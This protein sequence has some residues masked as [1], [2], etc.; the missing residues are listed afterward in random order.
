MA[1][2]FPASRASV[3]RR[4]EVAGRDGLA[5]V[6]NAVNGD[7]APAFYEE[8]QHARVQLADMAQLKQAIA[9]ALVSGSR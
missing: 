2:A 6:A 8:P 5:F 3:P 9:S 4:V 7:D 1:H